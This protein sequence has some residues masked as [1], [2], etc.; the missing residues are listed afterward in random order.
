MRAH[1]LQHVEFEGPGSITPWLT[2]RGWSI[3]SQLVSEST[4]FPDPAEIDFLIIMGG[5][6]SVH[7]DAAHPWLVA[8][9]SFIK[10]FLDTSKP[11]LGI[12]L[13]AQLIASV[14]GASVHKNAC[15]E[16]GWFPI[17]GTT[18]TTPDTFQFPAST[19]AFHWH[20]DTFAL[21]AN[22]TLLA[23]SEACTNQAFQFG[24]A[25]IGLQF[26]L[27]TTTES[28][29]ALIEHGRDE[30]EPSEFVH[31]ENQILAQE[32]AHYQILNQEMTRLLEWLTSR[33]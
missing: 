15:P 32:P 26:H 8:E 7:D 3:T 23:S 12:C 13:G 14:L 4:A 20:G 28:I 9:K 25:T 18:P 31:S 29:H 16:I 10:A 19:E 1:I 2:T 17:E 6:M 5:P 21:P 27:E 30:L 11:T 24:N 33:C 22:A